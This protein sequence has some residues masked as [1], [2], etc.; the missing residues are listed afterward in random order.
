MIAAEDA[1]GGDASSPTDRSMPAV[2][3]T[4]VIPI[5]STPTTLAW[6]SMLRTLSQVGNVSGFRIA[7]ATNSSDDDDRER[8]LLEL[9]GR[10]R[11]SA[12]VQRPASFIRPPRRD[13][14]YRWARPRGEAARA[15]WRPSP[16]TSATI[17]PSR[18]TRMRVQMPTSSSS[19]DETTSTPRPE[20]GEVADDPVDLGLGRDVDA[21]R[22]LVEQ[23]HPALAQQPAREH[24][25]LLVAAREQARPSRSG[26]SGTV[27]SARS[28]SRAASRSLADVEQR[29]ARSGRGR[30]ASRSSSGSSRARGACDLR[31]SGARPEAR[32][33]SRR[34][35]GR[36]AARLPSTRT[37]PS[38]GGSRP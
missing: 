17:S 26:S 5:A 22:R 24:D 3:I 8:V 2:A 10:G 9:E 18:M 13:R 6:V 11:A 32:G 16:S 15:R 23:Q 7:P 27:F 34:A 38:S 29:R 19:S 12:A 33:G 31:S 14:G 30:R 28:C 35:G 36:A 25:L 1:G 37:S 4:N 21:A 20:L